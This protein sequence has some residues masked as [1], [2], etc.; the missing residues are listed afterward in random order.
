MIKFMG[1]PYFPLKYSS[2]VGGNHDPVPL[3]WETVRLITAYNAYL[4]VFWTYN[5]SFYAGL[6]APMADRHF[7]QNP[8][9]T[10]S[11]M[12]ANGLIN[13]SGQV[14]PGNYI[15]ANLGDYDCVSWTLNDVGITRYGD[16]MRG[17]AACN[18]WSGPTKSGSCWMRRTIPPALA[19]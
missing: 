13:G 11:Q 19:R 1:F 16:P 17:Q 14:V 18:C 15:L 4:E 8:A 6:K 12:A 10:Y 7:V 2:E 5:T 9:P 3:E